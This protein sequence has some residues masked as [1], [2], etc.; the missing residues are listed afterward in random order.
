MKI[1]LVE[2][3]LDL[4]DVTAYS[5]RRERFAVIE[6][7]DGVQALH[8]WKVDRPDLIVL[9]LGLPRHDGFE[10]L[11]RIREKD[12]TPIVVLSGRGNEDD[13]SRAFTIGADDFVAKPFAAK[14]LALRIRAILRRSSAEPAVESE[15]TLVLG[16][17][18]I[19]PEIQEV[20]WADA[21]IRLTPTEFRI[22]HILA[23]HVGRIVTT[24]RLLAYVWGYEGGD[25][26]ALRT[27]ISHLRTKLDLKTRDAAV[28][29]VTGVGYRLVLAAAQPSAGAA[30][31]RP[32]LAT[33]AR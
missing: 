3:D 18:R 14:H 5:L 23:M 20:R 25:P 28:V 31:L 2:D 4:L 32:R 16:D 27:H 7:A 1:L 8:R 22:F 15:P 6:A 17:I 12:S 19:D 24:S 10:V 13:I 11:Q 21:D 29:G 26:N 30:E 33:A 9:D